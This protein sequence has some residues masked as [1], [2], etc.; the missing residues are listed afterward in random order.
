MAKVLQHRYR[1]PAV[2][3]VKQILTSHHYTG[4][5]GQHGRGT[6]EDQERMEDWTY[7]CRETKRKQARRGGKEL[8]RMETG[9]RGPGGRTDRTENITQGEYRGRHGGPQDTRMG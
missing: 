2:N 8:R 7:K 1:I 6:R 4:Q 5:D 3:G 9:L